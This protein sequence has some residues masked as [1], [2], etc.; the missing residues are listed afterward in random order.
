[1]NRNIIYITLALLSAVILNSC[2]DDDGSFDNKLF[3]TSAKVATTF[4]KPGVNENEQYIEASIAKPVDYDVKITYKVDETLVE[5]YNKA[6][7]DNAIIMPSGTYEIPEP[8]T[9]IAAGNVAST[10]LTVKFMNLDQLDTKLIYVLPVTISDANLDIL[11]STRTTYYVFKGAS[12]INVVA[13][14]ENNFLQPKDKKWS[15][16]SV[17]A[18]LETFTMEALVN[19]RS[20]QKNGTVTTV[21]G[22]EGY[23]LIRIGDNSIPRNQIEVVKPDDS[24]V[25]GLES[26]IA[27]NKWV[28]IAVTYKKGEKIQIFV[29]GQLHGE[30]NAYYSNI[31][32]TDGQDGFYIGRSYDNSRYMEGAISE[33]R[34]WNVVRTQE[35]ITSTIYSVPADS[36]GL[37]AYWKCDEGEGSAV[38]D[39][40]KNG[41]DLVSSS[42][43]KWI[44]VTLP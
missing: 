38:K 29:D 5:S 12:L 14:M 7:Y 32:F 1:M 40:T 42:P 23:F 34:I 16:P 8:T 11:N 30:G 37:V 10:K 17:L 19:V 9:T 44:P 41:N 26:G 24:K 21:M 25:R 15:N 20:F 3:N 31:T 43:I 18:N 2:R 35:D 27:D 4:L 6:Y 39:H 36:P 33:C 13:D 22:I 28:H